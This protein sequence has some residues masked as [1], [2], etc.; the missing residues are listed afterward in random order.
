MGKSKLGRGHMSEQPNI[1]FFF[2]DDQRF[3]TI[4]AL[5]NSEIQT[6]H[7]DCLVERGTAFTQ[8]HI[9]CGTSGAV[10][11]PSRAMLHT[12][13]TLFHLERE[14]Q[15]IPPE[16]TTLG[17]TLQQAGYR[18]F[19]TGKWHNGTASF[20][21]SFTDGGEIF[22]G[23]MWDHWNVP[24]CDYDP[25]GEYDLV[26]PWIKDAFYSN[27]P[28]HVV[29][30]HL[31]PG[32]HSTELF[33][34]VSV[35]F[36]EEYRDEAPFFMYI[37]FMAPHDPRSMPKAFLDLYDPEA[38]TLPANYKDEHP[39]DF[40]IRNVRD[41]VLAPYPRTP[42]IVRQHLAEYYAMISHLDHEVGRVVKAIE[43]KG[44]LDNTLFIFAGD[45]G[46]ALGQ[47]G[48]FGK[49]NH[50][51]HSVRVPLIFGGPGIP[52]GQQRDTYAYLLDIFP[53]ICDLL[54][55]DVPSSVE[56]RSLL[57]AISD[58]AATHRDELYFAYTDMLR[59]VKDDRY[60]LVEYI[61]NGQNTT[62]LFDLVD[63]PAEINSLADDPEHVDRITQLRE[64]LC[65]FR[66]EWDD[67]QHHMG[68]SFWS[69]YDRLNPS[70]RRSG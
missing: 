39:F 68:N 1:V 70:V 25:T 17:E 24:A 19:G 8:A 4:G 37:S 56:G 15:N 2:T 7:I 35:A 13:R 40:G 69:E 3:D 20:A 23:G 62:Q 16:H 5:G 54:A 61:H 27:K 9:P 6:P 14:G 33:G 36:I 53:T 60:K 18:T 52:A 22:F 28:V 57:S 29:A 50:Y 63:D 47:H 32:K 26:K 64:R 66:D 12:G 43:E 44:Q 59:S 38:L 41:E 30:D 45:N 67:R 31:S 49:Q 21:R 58:G 48:L 11:M 42:E 46:L 55:V 34:D 51:E 65:A 10:C